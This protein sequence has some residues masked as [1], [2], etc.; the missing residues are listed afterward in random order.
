MRT[1]HRLALAT[2]LACVL[3]APAAATSF[4]TAE[5]VDAGLLLPPP[6]ANDSPRE[7]A[8]LAELKAIAAQ[9]TPAEFAAA[10]AD[11]KDETGDWFASAIGPGFDFA[12]L[13]V[14]AH[15]L[16]DIGE[17]EDVVA[18]GAKKYFQRDRPWTVAPDLETC[19]PKKPGPAKNSYPSGH[20]TR[21]FAMGVTL[22]HLMPAKAQPILARAE[23]YG[24]ERLICGVHFRSDIV[25][26]EA[27]GTAI[28][29]QLQLSPDFR[30]EYDAA[31]AELTAVGLRS[32]P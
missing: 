4:L 11:A 24:E 31:A 23:L 6:P 22:A 1:L 16:A 20:A 3:V 9:R 19:T 2:A 10:T 32:A 30:K 21:A 17:T 25:A 12:K 7:A 5:Q 8:E 18:K 29:L 26:G 14:T 13:P 15:L 27:L 28:A